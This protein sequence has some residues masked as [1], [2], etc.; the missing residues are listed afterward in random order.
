M[1][2]SGALLCSVA[3]MLGGCGSAASYDYDMP[4]VVDPPA[5]ASMRGIIKGMADAN[6]ERVR[7]ALVW[8]PVSPGEGKVQVSQNAESRPGPVDFGRDAVYPTFEIDI[9]QEPPAKAIEGSG[10]M[11]FGQA[12]VVLYEDR[13]DNSEFDIVGGSASPDRVIGRANGVRLWW[14]GAGSPAPSGFRGYKPVT[15]GWSLTYGPTVAEPSSPGEFGDCAPDP[16]PGGAWHRPCPLRLKEPAVDVPLADPFTIIVSNEPAL[17]SYACLGYWG[18]NSE[19]S[20]EWPDDTPGWHA[21]SLRSQICNVESCDCKQNC[22]L[23]LPVKGR[24]LKTGLMCSESKRAYFWKDCIRDPK[25]C[26][27]VFCHYGHGEL[28]DGEK[29]PADWPCK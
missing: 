26:N 28:K 1:R 24:E 29:P 19:K 10:S 7:V 5:L 4:P 25:L 3:V 18:T 11:R 15:A 6:R 14:L 17:Q 27:T 2:I 23:D 9:S 13:N 12:E 20:D 8:L 22:P 21:P 16:E